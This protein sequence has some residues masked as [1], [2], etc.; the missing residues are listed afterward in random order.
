MMIIVIHTAQVDTQE[1]FEDSFR[2]IAVDRW[3]N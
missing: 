3:I 2:P 1:S